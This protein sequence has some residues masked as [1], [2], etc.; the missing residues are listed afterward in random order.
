MVPKPTKIQQRAA[1]WQ[2]PTGLTDGLP[3][4]LPL[5][6]GTLWSSVI[7]SS[8]ICICYGAKT[9]RSTVLP[10]GTTVLWHFVGKRTVDF[11]GRVVS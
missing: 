1:K 11:S 8:I 2:V 4:V 10:P 9:K 6:T 7:V 5:T 3:S